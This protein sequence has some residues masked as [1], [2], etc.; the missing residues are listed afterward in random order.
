MVVAALAGDRYAAIKHGWPR[1]LHEVSTSKR[2]KG[3]SAERMARTLERRAARQ[4]DRRVSRVN[5]ASPAHE[6][7]D[8]RKRVKRFRY[9]LDH[10]SDVLPKREVKAAIAATKQLQDDLGSFQDNEVHE[11]LVSDLLRSS[12]PLSAAATTA[13]RALVDRYGERRVDFRHALDDQL[14][15]FRATAP[16]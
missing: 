12:P 10:F 7:H 14:A 16:A 4:L 2:A 3:L 6:I 15:R 11:Q 8:A 13:A 1:V 9:T 5:G